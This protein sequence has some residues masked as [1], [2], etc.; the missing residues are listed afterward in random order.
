MSE[1]IRGSIELVNSFIS[2]WR[3][4]WF[5]QLNSEQGSFLEFLVTKALVFLFRREREVIETVASGS[6]F[7]K[8]INIGT[9]LLEEFSS[10]NFLCSCALVCVNSS[11]QICNLLDVKSS[12][13]IPF[14]YCMNLL[15][16]LWNCYKANSYLLYES[17][18]KQTHHPNSIIL[19]TSLNCHILHL[20]WIHSKR[21]RHSVVGIIFPF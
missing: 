19:D 16:S 8:C 9:T 2:L 10:Q 12:Q 7:Y 1:F 20:N 21:V 11:T 17:V 6:E 13:S 15:H 4:C 18:T 3:I 5:Y 14:Q